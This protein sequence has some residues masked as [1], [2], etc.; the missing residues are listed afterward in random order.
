[1]FGELKLNESDFI[2]FTPEGGLAV[3]LLNRT[4]GPTTKGYVVTTDTTVKG[5]F[6][7][8]PNGDPD[9]IG[10]VYDDGIA[11]SL[12]CWVVVS[13]IA[14]VNFAASIST[15]WFARSQVT[16]SAYTIGLAVGEA[17][18]TPPFATDKHFL[19]IGHILDG[20]SAGL[21]KCILHFN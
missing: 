3:K 19:E 16:A 15:G 12:A 10:V 18:P 21:H 4:G 20:G 7:Y 14:E 9:P 13:G 11:H 8:I 6:T 5:G 1:M 2:K 17:L